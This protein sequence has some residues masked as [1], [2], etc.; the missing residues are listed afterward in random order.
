MHI[1]E[2]VLGLFVALGCL[3]WFL[4][5]REHRLGPRSGNPV[6]PDWSTIGSYVDLVAAA[7]K[8]DWLS[9]DQYLDGPFRRFLEMGSDPADYPRARARALEFARASMLG[10][11]ELQAARGAEPGALER[12]ARA[13]PA[14][15]FGRPDVPNGDYMLEVLDGISTHN[16]RGKRED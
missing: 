2:I 14:E 7:S 4:R 1:L 5:R 12:R 9:P 10:F 3:E 11:G 8:A 13:M 6:Q 15:W 16:A